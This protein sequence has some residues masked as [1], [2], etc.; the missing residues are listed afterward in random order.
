MGKASTKVSR[1]L[2]RVGR[3]LGA[4]GLVLLVDEVNQLYKKHQNGEISDHDAKNELIKITAGALGG[5]GGATIG[6]MLGSL[7]APVAGT[8]VGGV[9]GGI[10]GGWF[11]EEIATKAID[12][13]ENNEIPTSAQEL[14][15]MAKRYVKEHGGDKWG[16]ESSWTEW[17][18]QNTIGKSKEYV[19]EHGGDQW[20]TDQSYSEWGADTINSIKRYIEKTVA[21]QVASLPA[22]GAR[23]NDVMTQNERLNIESMTSTPVVNSFN[24]FNTSTKG[25]SSNYI[26]GEQKVRNDSLTTYR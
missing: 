2:Q 16:S 10:G 11:A 22:S 23:Y 14:Q 9:A 24:N 5:A 21:E 15:S 6:A 4:V 19:K 26:N 3:V 12:Y 13:F 20:G 17:F 18:H 25:S 8:F 1:S 7:V